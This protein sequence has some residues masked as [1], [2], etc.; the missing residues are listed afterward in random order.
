MGGGEE[1]EVL[2]DAGDEAGGQ[3]GGLLEGA[4]GIG[5]DGAVVTLGAAVLVLVS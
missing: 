3:G 2:G 1:F 4:A 5:A